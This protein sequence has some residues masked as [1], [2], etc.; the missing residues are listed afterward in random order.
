MAALGG[1]LLLFV[2]WCGIGFSIE[3]GWPLWQGICL[4]FG[5]TIAIIAGA[6]GTFFLFKAIARKVIK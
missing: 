5:M 4:F 1:I 2:I 6:V 3:G